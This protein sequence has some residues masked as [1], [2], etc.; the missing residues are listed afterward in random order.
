MTLGPNLY[1]SIRQKIDADF[2]VEQSELDARRRKAIEA[3]NEAWPKMGGSE[4]DLKTLS[5]EAFGRKGSAVVSS[6][7]PVPQSNGSAGRT[8]PMKAI[9][10]EVENFLD[11]VGTGMITQTE[12]KDRVLSKYPDAKMPS[13]RSAISH[14]LSDLTKQ[15]KLELVEKGKAGSP[16]KYRKRNVRE[17]DM[18]DN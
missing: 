11:E 12:I 17:L 10:V 3:L 15:G 5:T 18:F 16:H 6:R 14:F 1:K 4:E 7:E 9:G 8:V 2:D 13:V